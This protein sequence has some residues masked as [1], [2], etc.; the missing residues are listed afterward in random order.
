MKTWTDFGLEFPDQFTGERYSTCPQCSEKRTKKKVKCLSANGEKF[1]W[2]CHHCGWS[3][4][5]AEG[6]V[7]KSEH[8][9]QAPKEYHKPDYKPNFSKIPT[10]ICQMV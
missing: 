5:L 9:K 10:T 6:E 4:T 2:I 7:Y 3:G 1:A 8:I